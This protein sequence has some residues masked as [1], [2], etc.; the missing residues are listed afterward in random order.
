[1]SYW[2]LGCVPQWLF[3]NPRF[4]PT[5]PLPSP[6]ATH[7]PTTLPSSHILLSLSCHNNDS[8]LSI[9]HSTHHY[10]CLR[11]SE[12]DFGG[13]RVA[14]ARDIVIPYCICVFTLTDTHSVMQTA[15]QEAHHQPPST[16]T[17][18][19]HCAHTVKYS[20]L[21]PAVTDTAFIQ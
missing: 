5:I 10:Y 14:Q 7:S 15:H 19:L 21:L 13:E 20:T 16:S 11:A 6:V 9:P 1:M 18:T 17:T 3:I 8:T 12:Y 2:P 4:P